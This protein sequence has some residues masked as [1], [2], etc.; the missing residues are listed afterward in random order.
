MAWTPTANLQ[1]PAGPTGD[2]GLTGATGS[3]GPAGAT[4]PAGDDAMAIPAGTY[5]GSWSDAGPA[6]PN[7]NPNGEGGMAVTGPTLVTDIN[8]P[9][10][11]AVGCSLSNGTVTVNQTG[12]WSFQ[13][14]T[15]YGGGNSAIRAVY[16][17]QSTSPTAAPKFGLFGAPSADSMATSATFT[18]A[19]GDKVSFCTDLWSG[20]GLGVWKNKGCTIAATWM[21]NPQLPATGTPPPVVVPLA[22]TSP[23]ATDASQ[24]NLFRATIA[25]NRTLSAPT[26][27][28]DGQRIV[29][30]ITASGGA[31]T[32]SLATGAGGFAFGSDTSAL[33]AIASGTTDMLA[34]I[35]NAAVNRWRVVAYSKGF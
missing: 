22:D 5:R 30:E 2:R 33:S 9:I 1:G 21:G 16:F 6:N 18:L 11:T 14:T 31:R 12:V 34:A 35:Y 32:L 27:P 23:L 3:A 19:A 8:T 25:G 7:A 15:Q 4:G 13:G 24:G 20:S 28:A 17:V 26:N 29:W 10:G